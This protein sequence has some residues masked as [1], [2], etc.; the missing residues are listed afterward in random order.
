MSTDEER[1]ELHEIYALLEKSLKWGKFIAMGGF[2]LGVWTTTIELRQQGFK[3]AVKK[4]NE[5]H[6]RANQILS[7]LVEWKTHV[8]GTRWS[9]QDHVNYEKK[10]Q[11]HD[12]KMF[13]AMQA[14]ENLQE[15]RLQRLEDTQKRLSDILDTKFEVVPADVL[16]ELRELR[17]QL[18]Q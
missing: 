5:H 15:L 9:I 4:A 14:R 7:E 13:A 17:E 8:N 10:K 12:D 3:D 18:G 11:E 6:A 2:M 16:R 1:H